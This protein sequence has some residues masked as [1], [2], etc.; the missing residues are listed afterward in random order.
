MIALSG[1]HIAPRHKAPRSCA[2]TLARLTGAVPVSAAASTLVLLAGAAA[3]VGVLAVSGDASGGE[4]VAAPAGAGEAAGPAI[5]PS[6]ALTPG[7]PKA[8]TGATAAGSDPAV[9]AALSERTL[10][11]QGRSDRTVSRAGSRPALL[12]VQRRTKSTAMPVA[13]QDVSG[14]VTEEVQPV[15]PSDPR[16]IAMSML[17]QYGWSSDQF[18]C[19]DELYLHESGWNPS[20]ANPSSGAY[21]IPQALPGD[22]MAAYGADW[23]TNPAT[24]LAWGLAYIRDSYGS[25]CGAWGFWESNNW[26]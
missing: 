8:P 4:T 23:Q 18:S 11:S 9:A 15:Q 16:D 19:L 6:E 13:K 12:S 3:T 2:R 22:K 14:A 25:P 20:A 24:Q 1:R 26:Y 7:V 5:A 17:A 21:G 10:A